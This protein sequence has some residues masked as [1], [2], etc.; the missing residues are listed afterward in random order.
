MTYKNHP[1]SKFTVL[2]TGATGGIGSALSLEYAKDNVLLILLGRSIDELSYLAEECRSCGAEVKTYCH[3][4]SA[5]EKSVSLSAEIAQTHNVDLFISNA[6]ITNSTQNCET[7]SWNKIESVISLNLLGALAISHGVLEDMQR[8]KS[9]HIAYVSSLGAYYG[10]P[11]TPS[12]CASKAGLKAYTEAVRGLLAS[13]SITVTLIAPGF[14]KTPLS[15]QF[16]GSKPFMISAEDAARI[17][18][19]GLDK[20]KRVIAFPLA[21]NLGVRFLSLLPAGIS[22]FIL[23]RLKY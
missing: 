13:Q 8:R 14:V 16:R 2:I 10:M 18:R 15:D 5:I 21:L 4:L 23:A 20:K 3:D 7:E 17:I 22:D 6:G 11:L 19:R 12:Y 1:D 9:G